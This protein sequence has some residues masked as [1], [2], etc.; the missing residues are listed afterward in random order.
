VERSNHVERLPRRDGVHED[1]AVHTNG[2][3]GREE[4]ELILR[5][6]R[7]PCDIPK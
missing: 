3:L 6:Q 7:C 1:V 5:G 2:V 4:R